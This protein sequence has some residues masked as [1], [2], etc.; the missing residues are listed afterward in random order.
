MKK[1]ISY[2]D[3]LAKL[4]P[5][6][7]AM[8]E[9]RLARR[10]ESEP[11]ETRIPKRAEKMYAPLSFAQ[12]RLWLLDR[13]LPD[14][15]VYNMPF[16]VR[17][18]GR[19]DRAALQQA[20]VQ[21]IARH[22]SLRTSFIERDGEPMQMIS[23]Q[24]GLDLS[25][26]DLSALSAAEQ[27]RA[28]QMQVKESASKRFDLRSG[29][30]IRCT[31]LSI[32]EEEH[33]LL[34]ALHHIVGDAWSI[35]ILIKEFSQLYEAFSSDQSSPLA[36]L[37]VQYGDYAAWQRANANG[38][39]WQGQLAYWIDRLADRLPVLDLPA[40]RP[41]PAIQSYRG[42][43]ERFHLASELT[44][45][46]RAF[47]QKS[48][49][50]MFMTLLASFFTFLHRYSGAEDLA[51]GTPIAGRRARETE[52]L[53]GFFVNTLVMRQKVLPRMTFEQLAREVYALAIDAFANQDIPFDLLVQQL[54]PERDL[55]RSPLVQ[56]MFTLQNAPVSNIELSGLVLTPVEQELES[57][58]FD[59]TLSVVEGEQD[60][61]CTFEYN[62][63]LWDRATILRMI[64]QFQN[65]LTDIL[66]DPLRP[67]EHLEVLTKQE[68]YTLLQEW[69]NTEC[70]FPQA[71]LP[72][73]FDELAALYPDRI[74]VSTDE[75]SVTY[76][77]LQARANRVA[78]QLLADGVGPGQI[79]GILL[80]RSIEGIVAILGVLKAGAAYL[81]LDPDY[82]KDR[83]NYMLQDS[84]VKRLITDRLQ[85]GIPSHLFDHVTYLDQIQLQTPCDSPV[86]SAS[87]DDLA[88]VIYTSGSS[89][90]PKGT[91]LR[92]VGVSNL[93]AWKR[94]EFNY[95]E[96]EIILQFSSFSFDASVEEIF[97]TLLCGAHLHLLSDE[98]RISAEEFAKSV[99]RTKATAVTVP[100]AFFR[101]LAE[102][103]SNEWQ[104]KLHSLQKIFVAGEALAGHAVDSWQQRMGTRIEIINAYGPTESTVCA[105]AYRIPDR[106]QKGSAPVPI[107]KALPN[108]KTYILGANGQPCPIGVPGELHLAS[109]G[110]T[111]GYLDQ[112]ALTQQVLLPNRYTDLYGGTLYKTGDLARYLPDGRIE[113][114]GRVDKQI[115]VRGFRIEPGEIEA[116]LASHPDVREAVVVLKEVSGEK[117]VIAYL[118]TFENKDWREWL[119]AKVP[120]Y[121]V[122]SFFVELQELPLTANGKVDEKALPMPESKSDRH[123]RSETN[124]PL[125]ELI[126]GVFAHVLQREHVSPDDN[127]FSLGGHSLLATQVIT[128]LNEL[129]R[130]DFPLRLLFEFPTVS[131]LAE[132][133]D[134]LQQT[135]LQAQT[136]A[137][138]PVSREEALP[139]S[140]AQQ[141]MWMLDQL[142][143]DRTVYSIPIA[144]RLQ[145]DLRADAVEQAL[146]KLIARHEALRTTFSERAGEPVQRIEPFQPR[147]LP[148]LDLSEC[149]PGQREEEVRRL[150]QGEASQPF[151]LQTGPL[152]RSRLLKLEEQEHVLLLNMHHIISDAWSMNVFV[153]E[154]TSFY[155][156]CREGN[157]ASIPDLP[158]QYA[159]Y[160]THQRRMLQGEMMEQ[161]LNYWRNHLCG[162]LP[163][164][165][166]PTDRPRPPVQTHEGGAV[167]FELDA[168][169]T[170]RLLTLS[171]HCG[172]TLF[173]TLLGGF[174]SLLARY[175]GQTDIIVGT[176][177]AGRR[178]QETE[179]LIGCFV[180]TLVMRTDLAND[181][182]FAE[183]IG[184]VREVALGA[185][186]HQDVPFERL[187]EEF[188]PERDRSRS[189][190][191]Q[192][193]FSLQN[194]PASDVHLS[195][196]TLSVL[197]AEERSAK[198]DLTLAMTQL[199]SG[200]AGS[201]EYSTDLFDRATISRM[202]AHFENLL[203]SAAHDAGQRLSELSLLSEQERHQLI[204][205]WNQTDV[206]Y[207]QD[208]CLHQ[209]IEERV[210]KTP[211]A[212]A[213]VFG[214]QTL[215]FSALN[216]AANRLAIRLRQEGVGP[217]LFVGICM[218]RSDQMI[219]AM[220]A[221]LKAGGAY[222]PLDPTYP[223]ERLAF[224]IEDSKPVLIVAQSR[225]SHLFTSCAA[226]VLYIDQ[227]QT[228]SSPEPAE[229]IAVAVSSDLPAYMIYTSGSTGKPKGVMISHRSI[230]NQLLWLI[231][232]YNFAAEDRILLKTPTSF[233]ASVWEIFAPLASGAQLIIAPDWQQDVQ[234]LSAAITRH[235]VTVLQVVPS[236]LRTLLEQEM[237]PVTGIRHVFC[238]GETL[239]KE[240]AEQ[241]FDRCEAK[242]HNLY[243]PTET[244]INAIAWECERQSESTIVPIGRPVA[245][246]RVYL[247]D[248]HQ[249]PV[250]IGVAGELYI[251]GR[252]VGIGY[253]NRPEQN[254]RSFLP[255]PF[256][257]HAQDLLYR[258]GDL[259]RYRPD[260]TLESLGRLDHQVKI[261]GF[262]IELDEIR[263]TC[264]QHPLLSDALVLA[265]DYEGGDKRLIAYYVPQEGSL[266]KAEDVRQHLADSL[267]AYMV[268][269][270][271]IRMERMPLLPNGKIDRNALPTPD[272][273][274]GERDS[275]VPP[276]TP[277]EELIAG[278][279]QELLALEQVSVHDDFFLLG[280]H[281]LLATQ[282]LL[283]M[284]DAFGVNLKL[285]VLFDHPTIFALSKR[286]EEMRHREQ[287]S[288]EQSIVPSS[289][290]QPIPL[291]F[292][293]QRLW[294]LEQFLPD[295]ALY[296][297]PY[298]LRLRGNLNTSA[299]EWSFDKII[300]RHQV[301]RTTFV[302]TEGSVYQSV[303]S[304]IELPFSKVDLRDVDHPNREAKMNER[305]RAAIEQPFDLQRGPLIRVLLLQ[306]EQ[307]EHLLV[308]N[309]H[310]IVSDGWSMKILLE[311]FVAFY[312]A[313]IENEQ[314]SLAEL[315]IQYADYAQ[316]QRDRM[317]GEH[318]EAQLSYWRE[319]L[320]GEL[321]VLQLPT[322]RPRPPQQTFSGASKSFAV[323]RATLEA[324]RKLSH[325]RSAT[326][327]MTLLA[328]YKT[329][330]YRYSGQ[331]DICVGTPVAGR[332]RQEA[333]HLIGI[334]INT[335]V[336]RTH[337]SGDLTFEELLHRVRE[338][339]LSAYMHQDVSFE[340]LVEELQPE[341]DM[342]RSPLFQTMFV[343]QNTPDAEVE[344]PGI[345][346]QPHPFDHAVAKFDLTFAIGEHEQGLSGM[347]EYNTDLFDEATIDRM[348]GHFQTL[349]HQ[350]AEQPAQRLPQLPMLL[351]AERNQL[352]IEWN[353]TQIEFPR[354][355]T[356][357]ELFDERVA[358]HPNRIAVSDREG[359]LTYQEL[360]QQ[361]DRLAHWLSDHGAKANQIVGMMMNRSRHALVAIL[362]I[363]KSGAAYLPIDPEYPQERIAYL[364][365]DSGAR[366]IVTEQALLDKI[367][368]TNKTLLCVEDTPAQ[369]LTR[370]EPGCT[371]EDLAYVIYTS[372]ST[373]RPK[374]TLI[375][376]IGVVNL[377]QFKGREFAYS[378]ETVLQFC[379]FSFDSSVW[380]T[381]CDLLNGV[382]VRILA[383]E[384]RHSIQEFA[385]VV[386][387]TKATMT[388]L[389]ASFFH[390]LG[391]FLSAEDAAKFATLKRVFVT[392]EALTGEA[393]RA[394]QR[395][396]GDQIE[397]INGYGPTEATIGA[398]THRVRALIPADQISIPIGRPMP[399]IEVF[400]LTAAQEL[401]PINII[402][403]IYISSV[404]L[405]TG[406]HN[407][408]EKTAE[409]FLPH[410][411]S[412]DPGARV[413]KTGD[414]GRYLP[415]GRI[416][417]MGRVD[418]Q[419][420][421]RGFRVE[422][423]EIEAVL[424]AHQEVSSTAVLALDDE[425][426]SKRLVAYV[427]P[428]ED[429][430]MKSTELR[431]FLLSRLPSYLV[432]PV[433]LML[434]QMPLTPNGKIDRKSLPL[435]DASQLAGTSNYEPPR[436]SLER[437]ITSIW[438]EV[439]GIP[440]LGVHD[441]FFDL[442]GHSLLATQILSR[443]QS[444]FQFQIPLRSLFESPTVAQ[445]ATHLIEV[446][447][448]ADLSSSHL[449]VQ[450]PKASREHHLPLSFAQ[451]RMWVL[452]RFLTDRSA[453]NVPL[454]VQLD[455]PLNIQ[456]LEASLNA[457]IVRHE[458]LRTTFAEVEGQLVQIIA[459]GLEL[460]LALVDLSEFPLGVRSQEAT[461]LIEQEVSCPF[462]LNEGPLIRFHLL[463]LEDQA[464]ILVLNLH[465]IVTDGWS[466]NIFVQEVASFY[467]AFTNGEEVKLPELP[468][469]YGDYSA[470]QRHPEQAEML[471]QQLAYWQHALRGDLPVL[472][473]P[474]DRPRPAQQTHLGGLERFSV[475]QEIATA[476]RSLGQERAAT[477]FMTLLAAFA[478][479]L[480]RYTAQSDICIGTPVAGRQHPETEG[481]IGCFLNT[482]V[483]RTDLS[484]DPSFAGLVDRVRETALGAFANQDVPFESLVE[485]LQPEPDLSRTPLFQAMFTLQN[486]P[487]SQIDL[488]ELTIRLLDAE[489]HVAK[490]D[491]HLTVTEQTEHLSGSFVY[492]AD[493]F[494][495]ETILR[496]K[497][498]FLNLLSEAITD[499]QK[500]ISQLAMLST[501]ERSELIATPAVTEREVSH[502][503]LHQQF[504]AIVDRAP[505]RVAIVCE[506]NSLTYRELNERANRVAAHLLSLGVQ[507]NTLVGLCTERS[508]DLVIGLLAILK[509]GGAYVPLDPAYPADRLAFLLQ[510]A[511]LSILLTQQH[512]L[513]ALPAH[514]AQVVCLDDHALF[515]TASADNPHSG[516]T[517]ESIAY[518]IY[519][520][521]STGQPKGVPI[522]HANVIRLF[523]STAHW[524]PFAEDD[525]W[526]LFHSFSFDFSVWEL[527][528]ALLHG[529]KAVI[530]PYW[531]SRSPDAFLHLL[532]SE[533][534]TVLNQTPS[535]FRQ[536]M[537]AE[538][539]ESDLQALS[540]RWVIFG[541]EALDLPALRPW[542]DRH[543]D[544]S[545]QL[546]NMYGITETTVHVTYRP[547]KSEDTMRANSVI[548]HPI[549]DLEVYVL[550]PHLEP[551]PIGVAGELYVGGAGVAPGYLHR[552]ELT[553]ER[554]LRHPFHADPQARLYKTGDLARRLPSGELEYL[555]RID[556]QVKI[557]GFRIELGEIESRIGE[558]PS[559]RETAVLVQEDRLE[560]KRIVTYVVPHVGS[561]LQPNDLLAY[562]KAHLPKYMVPSAFVL[563]DALPLTHN[564]KL[565]RNALPEPEVHHAHRLYVSPRDAIELKLS[566]MLGELL[567]LQQ[568]G[569]RDNFFEL[570]GHSILAVRLLAEI[571]QEFGQSI[572]LV[573]LY[574]N[575]TIEH[576][577]GLLRQASSLPQMSSLVPLKTK[578]EGTPL[579][580]VHP[581]SGIVQN[582]LPLASELNFPAVYALQSRGL[583]DDEELLLT[584][585]DMA[586][587]YLS[588]I[589]EVQP[590]GPYLL[591]GWSLGGVIAFEMAK[592][593]QKTGEEVALLALFDTPSPRRVLEEIDEMDD[594][595]LLLSM[596][597]EIAG[598]LGI[599]MSD[600]RKQVEKR[601]AEEGLVQLHSM[602]VEK[603]LLPPNF[604]LTQLIRYFDVYRANVK[605]QGK[606]ASPEESCVPAIA[607]FKAKEEE[608]TIYSDSAYGWHVFAKE[609]KVYEIPGGH[610]SMMQEPNIKTLAERLQR[611]LD[612]ACAVS[613]QK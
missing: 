493:L 50:T 294:V 324:L 236:L 554:F 559:V 47:N 267:P 284:N 153:K 581:G 420:K 482:L 76:R 188:H 584:I 533:R 121:L 459:A 599:E 146:N 448:R 422:L 604:S 379:S 157:A 306:L 528:G 30:P 42:A 331:E 124:R 417:Y 261:R 479:L 255:D 94:T 405:A 178:Q 155:A 116:V 185:Y 31:L 548:G 286:V 15:S 370:L 476:L 549:P 113:Y 57:A 307:D 104:Y 270:R 102:S 496:M 313:F 315:P 109:C 108:V 501:A 4:S 280:G 541:G 342:S 351:E 468:I 444:A 390:Q 478:T 266:L 41:R 253:F 499:S 518:V 453:Y 565:D 140:F 134:R 12:Q 460:P 214:D 132:K 393:A 22:E 302:E 348:I 210:R 234:L 230:V 171:R 238:G 127:F 272:Q 232:T 341:R 608:S 27:E 443:I 259:A 283:R 613:Y 368:D 43:K 322:D 265:K 574:Q 190:I 500:R 577:A 433:F 385:N 268:P 142:L 605:A 173:M 439:L 411:F 263:E 147:E 3:R 510:D 48:G 469:Q 98:A 357:H 488:P 326:L 484:D 160:A 402:G 137:I 240:V 256:S 481:L 394:W 275:F 99:E 7:R 494:D 128:R 273:L 436:T 46:L 312:R 591:G 87:L 58:K 239:P 389:P 572:P 410:P 172:A 408:P 304:R 426:G 81:P 242:L 325:Q 170:E 92:Q 207:P 251:G 205:E 503:T 498:H 340:R 5:A 158:I 119:L 179:G 441:N 211:A 404:G 60:L 19:L 362:G 175:S 245:N 430:A 26:V 521:G 25:S 202:I 35:S 507:P 519:T 243:G 233:D 149:S 131:R 293:Q 20:L 193:M 183:T 403:E 416:E 316:W 336:L 587:H 328:T 13:L 54:Q 56:V 163:L 17:L 143:S 522:P 285:R 299:M 374:G 461:R 217:N 21:I 579:F 446:G 511:S 350:I 524:F 53:I 55:S 504:E 107:G 547:L 347:I 278:I 68:R 561:E 144:V 556:H 338:T 168:E 361:S 219:I 161:Q 358:L 33:I 10:S 563:L 176:P 425:A 429:S 123:R 428:T 69:N 531:I 329:L 550:D 74:A 314:P 542:F 553:V 91:L 491:L 450:I 110:L 520:S 514:R 334:F 235:A 66:T 78:H 36:E 472:H 523:T 96:Q 320:R 145:G 544:Q 260:G 139:L 231:D 480:H 101:L 14:G 483:L 570:G 289:H 274:A 589:R 39:E 49:L 535:A 100:T 375:R 378:D 418:D 555:G 200:L 218:D 63:D 82:P 611:T 156:D 28:V 167:R 406:Y 45:Q 551:V 225:F 449:R 292:A 309:M 323:P 543:G 349:L 269:S 181:P 489:H 594:L 62:T 164:L 465:H 445:F 427:V 332:S 228:L 208:V 133:I 264:L 564:G 95:S 566:F 432:P 354:D 125:E 593:L 575:S 75:E 126:A 546:I 130:A 288:G 115:K 344:L 246:T 88:Y 59:L 330:L 237:L 597:E 451:Q 206:D 282:A 530:V 380:D 308:V 151:D 414:L 85:P 198:F 73:Q 421:I 189:P 227:E 485:A 371:A 538:A 174:Q 440:L 513:D 508:L 492:N 464:H 38:E 291:S 141:R 475:P 487:Q 196:L 462:D 477:L 221:I 356:I 138:T 252:G 447:N 558:H 136:L 455:G 37:P 505:D 363:L 248:Q 112:P 216:D 162:E 457:L 516:A 241:F 580:L 303:A 424:A 346:A 540:L 517:A 318:L 327:F 120:D 486:A 497:Q 29:R 612:E 212:T 165:Q 220:L 257:S 150:M 16:A 213:L 373:G 463:R 317:Q 311:E 601:G 79:V 192:V 84:S 359:R 352:L 562:T 384:E 18:T 366:L 401:C 71:P 396:F 415:D 135:G 203:R 271:Y 435:P 466:L 177:I 148:L 539:A 573:D 182:S 383:G 186:A 381:L 6:Q 527:W 586:D 607:L 335:L 382:H 343:F 442:G 154:F 571:K 72:V 474:T 209:L 89:G 117:C 467:D 249:Q 159:D 355:R 296:N 585:E 295:T 93:A 454:I 339:A 578:E 297:T 24:I 11:I 529:G 222:V 545:P 400:I 333:E 23:E 281:S 337:V 367:G 224:M 452:D 434:D 118:V 470:W 532:A 409:V 305:V 191:F 437:E 376:H 166:L 364:L 111:V 552:P 431:T 199:P 456:A 595:E 51:V 254:E 310:H 386:A 223:Q 377:A 525:V 610:H 576:I 582:Y 600:F 247:F 1:S 244:T 512:L 226:T 407:L 536:L 345:I 40:D 197:P 473:L 279:W 557:R 276:R 187:V 567:N 534:V 195:D 290:D 537:Q 590:H 152:F 67:I 52:D 64:S 471:K 9:K 44:Q 105:T 596:A 319:Q 258:T 65:L 526:T 34:L 588:E 300:E 298:A 569:I 2:E 80:K 568:V 399:N 204:C 262:R 419:V 395:H 560:D 509:A 388:A 277:T 413:Y 423:G 184:R 215:N 372:G 458:T 387:E 86:V 97:C 603:H 129:F 365:E 70:E 8:M 592:R 229:R 495:R 583:H 502:W 506:S 122:P 90:Q 391:N 301:L 515:A 490:Y 106:W 360:Q 353:D 83:L 287:G 194:T 397:I 398:T 602:A 598:Q 180:N 61:V 438:A 103:F 392:G 32:G 114:L 250:P 609:V 321:P 201:I 77:E 606:Y 169:L 412:A 369:P